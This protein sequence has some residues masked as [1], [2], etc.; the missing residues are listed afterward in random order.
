MFLVLK[1]T[2]YLFYSFVGVRVRVRVRNYRKD[3]KRIQKHSDSM[4]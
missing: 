2:Y 4:S 1:V 3:F